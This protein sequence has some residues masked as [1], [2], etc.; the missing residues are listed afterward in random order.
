MDIGTVIEEEGDDGHRTAEDGAMQ[1]MT[2]G[3]VDVVYQGRIRIE[4]GA[5]ACQLPRLGSPM[6]RMILLRT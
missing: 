2:A 4:V 3:A 5:N 6:D 1:R